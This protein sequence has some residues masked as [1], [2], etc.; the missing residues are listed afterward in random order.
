MTDRAEAKRLILRIERG[1]LAQAQLRVLLTEATATVA[2]HRKALRIL[3][4]G[5][6]RRQS[7]PGRRS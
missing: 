4:A 5:I 2:G 6:A 1:V 7:A 3:K